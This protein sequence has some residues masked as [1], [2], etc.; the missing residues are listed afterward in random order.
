[1]DFANT[2][3]SILGLFLVHHMSLRA[4]ALKILNERALQ[5]QFLLICCLILMNLLFLSGSR[6]VFLSC[7]LCTILIFPAITVTIYAQRAI[8][9]RKNQIRL[10][11]KIKM[12]VRAGTSLKKSWMD[13]LSDE[14]DWVKSHADRYQSSD[15]SLFYDHTFN[16]DMFACFAELAV[17]M[18]SNSRILEKI[19]SLIQ[20]KKVV[21]KLGQ[22]SSSAMAQARAQACAAAVI[23]FLVLVWRTALSEQ[24]ATT[25]MVLLSLILFALGSA[26]LIL[27]GR[28]FKWK[29]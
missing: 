12:K 7:L 24:K 28:R 9:W 22:K 3:V 21:Q 19:E 11:K 2:F 16:K 1:M 25:S 6:V 5:S 18:N 10:L 4:Q 15:V 29:T 14:P 13:A 20:T 8:W 26:I 27:I 17:V 23:Y